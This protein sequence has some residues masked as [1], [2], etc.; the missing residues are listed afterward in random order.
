MGKKRDAAVFA[1]RNHVDNC[2][3]CKAWK[4]DVYERAAAAPIYDWDRE[5]ER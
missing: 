4:A 5:G 2:K 1:Y 3:Q